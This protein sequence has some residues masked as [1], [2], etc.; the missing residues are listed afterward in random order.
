MMLLSKLK[1]VASEIYTGAAD[2][3]WIILWKDQPPIIGFTN[4]LTLGV[5][6]SYVKAME[7][8][9][10][11]SKSEFPRFTFSLPGNPELELTP[12]DPAEPVSMECAH[13]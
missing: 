13:P 12:A 4:A 2:F 9:F 10:R 6:K 5:G 7:N 1:K 3:A 11:M 8:A